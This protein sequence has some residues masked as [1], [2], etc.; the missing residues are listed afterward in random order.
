MVTRG[1]ALLDIA[2]GKENGAAPSSLANMSTN[3]GQVVRRS[4]IRRKSTNSS[5]TV[6][7]RD[8]GMTALLLRVAQVPIAA[9]LFS[10]L[11]CPVFAETTSSD[12][13][14]LRI[15]GGHQQRTRIANHQWQPR[16]LFH[17][18]GSQESPKRPR[19]RITGK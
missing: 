19:V 7:C 17:T 8:F 9:H 2:Q 13:M 12:P 5:V 4:I 15:C 16:R 10:N 14:T 1:V 11:C 3:A 18:I 6:S